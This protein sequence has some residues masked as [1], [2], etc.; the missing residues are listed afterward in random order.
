[1]AAAAASAR[2]KALDEAAAAA[3]PQQVREELLVDLLV[4][5]PA[6]EALV[7]AP[8]ISDPIW[9]RLLPEDLTELEA[10]LEESP[11]E[12]WDRSTPAERR[13]LALNYLA[14]YLRDD[15]LERA[16]LKADMPPDEVHAMARGLTAAGGDPYIADMVFDAVAHAGLSVPDGGTV[17]DF[18]GSSGRVLRMIAAARPDLRCLGCD[19]NEPAIAWAAEHLPMAEFFVS[20]Q[21][22]PLDVPD[23]SVDTAFAISIWSH[24]AEEPALA[25]L[26]EM[27]RVLRPGGALVLTTHGFDC[28][29]V[30]LRHGWIGR[31]TATAAL[32]A[33]VQHGH[34][35]VDVFGPDGDWG[36]QDVGWGN[37]YLTLD[38]LQANVS[39]QFA[40]RLLWPGYLDQVQDVIVLERR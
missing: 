18:G 13:R 25:W 39:G 12:L 30:Q 10:V 33:M 15:A 37:A 21:A 28:L 1:T 32:A 29:A 7:P 26:T 14:Y 8:V 24:F 3:N 38:W 16:G 11:R 34:H 40:T 20:P 2:R 5:R 17:L 6:P 9:S 4:A 36:V 22:P 23:A 35:F 31:E 19:P 27:H